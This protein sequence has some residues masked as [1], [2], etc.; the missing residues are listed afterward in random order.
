MPSPNRR[1]RS[2]LVVALLLIASAATCSAQDPGTSTRVEAAWLELGP[3]G[4]VITRAI[5]R[6]DAC[7]PARVDARIVVMAQRARPGPNFPVLS[8]EITLPEKVRRVVVRGHELEVPDGPPRR[9]A[10]LG[11]TGCRLKQ[12]DGFQ[13]CNDPDQWPFARIAKSVARYDPDLIIHVGD[14]LY[15]ARRSPDSLPG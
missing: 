12:V 6:E 15:L 8:C 2:I 9:I 7:P 4:A 1:A 5:T 10:V 3:G 11:D 13:A 14:I